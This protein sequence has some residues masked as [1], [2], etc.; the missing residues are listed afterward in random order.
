MVKDK[1]FCNKCKRWHRIKSKKF[2]EHRKSG[3]LGRWVKVGSV[4]KYKK[5]SADNLKSLGWYLENY[6]ERWLKEGI[7]ELVEMPINELYQWEYKDKI[8]KDSKK[9]ISIQADW[10]K[11]YRFPVIEVFIDNNN[12]PKIADGQHRW[13]AWKTMGRKSIPVILSR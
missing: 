9:I 10:K 6:Q 13:F 7:S 2:M 4:K 12:K 1:Y 3:N 8:T 5:I 11:G